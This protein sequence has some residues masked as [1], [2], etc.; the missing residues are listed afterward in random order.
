MYSCSYCQQEKL[1]SM[2]LQ[3]GRADPNIRPHINVQCTFVSWMTLV[4][5]TFSWG[6]NGVY[7]KIQN[8]VMFSSFLLVANITGI[9]IQK[10]KSVFK[11]NLN[12]QIHIY[13]AIYY[14]K[15][16]GKSLCF[17]ANKKILKPDTS[18]AK[19]SLCLIQ[20]NAKMLY[21][22]VEILA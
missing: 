6:M 10:I 15:V 1:Q 7:R 8:M 9:F 17:R 18:K 11:I 13:T 3:S 16:F 20:Q 19:L 21:G 4:V 2:T 5:L 12:T 22:G 14:L